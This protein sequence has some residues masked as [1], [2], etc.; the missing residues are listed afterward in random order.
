MAFQSAAAEIGKNRY[1]NAPRRAD[2]TI[3]QDWS[4]YSPAEHDRWDRL[5]ARSQACL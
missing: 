1:R 2:Y 4:S 5:F 3:D